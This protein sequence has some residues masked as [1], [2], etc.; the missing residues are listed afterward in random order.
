MS[1]SGLTPSDQELLEKHLWKSSATSV[2]SADYAQ[3][4]RRFDSVTKE[5]SVLREKYNR[6][7]TDFEIIR[8]KLADKEASLAAVSYTQAQSLQAAI[9][10]AVKTPRPQTQ[11]K[12]AK[13][14]AASGSPSKKAKVVKAPKGKCRVCFAKEGKEVDWANCIAH[15]RQLNDQAPPAV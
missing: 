12:R 8:A 13:A 4:I 5:C 7:Y 2:Q 10:A 11:G 9:S 15:N 14:A 6:L 1:T 3:Y